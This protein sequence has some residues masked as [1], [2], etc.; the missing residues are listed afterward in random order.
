M[1][2]IPFLKTVFLFVNQ[3]IGI[4][5]NFFMFGTLFF[6]F[7]LKNNL[8]F[9][10]GPMPF[11][12][13]AM[14]C[15]GLFWNRFCFQFINVERCLYLQISSL[16]VS[17]P[18]RITLTL[19]LRLHYCYCSSF[20][21]SSR[22]PWRP[23]SLLFF[24]LTRKGSSRWVVGWTSKWDRKTK[25]VPNGTEKQKHKFKGKENQWKNQSR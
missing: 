7:N 24:F 23:T 15:F 1:F 17:F 25:M 20:H 21:F 13:T 2:G 18:S 5:S 9:L 22:F 10:V 4:P 14:G 8:V 3:K 11:F 19:L 16:T 12:K 6:Y